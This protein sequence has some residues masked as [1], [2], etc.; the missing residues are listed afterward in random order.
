MFKTNCFVE[1]TISPSAKITDCPTGGQVVRSISGY[2]GK[3]NVSCSNVQ[4]HSVFLSSPF[5]EPSNCTCSSSS[6]CG[7]GHALQNLTSSSKAKIQQNGNH[8]F[9]YQSIFNSHKKYTHV[10]AQ[11]CFQNRKVWS[12]ILIRLWIT[13]LL[14]C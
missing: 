11:Y 14:L 3:S 5:G 2:Q 10:M 13:Y 4:F 8:R 1:E 6:F 7:A 9:S 12:Y